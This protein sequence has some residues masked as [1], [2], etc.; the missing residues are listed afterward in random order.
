MQNPHLQWLIRRSVTGYSL[1]AL[2]N[3]SQIV[4][5]DFTNPLE[6]AAAR[7]S[8]AAALNAY[9]SVEVGSAPLN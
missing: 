5:G 9:P 1:I 4:V 6:A 2:A 3:N 8:I 7:S